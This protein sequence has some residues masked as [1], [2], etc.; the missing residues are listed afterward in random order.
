M[1]A[2]ARHAARPTFI[3]MFTKSR[4][5][6]RHKPEPVQEQKIVVGSGSFT[7]VQDSTQGYRCATAATKPSYPDREIRIGEAALQPLGK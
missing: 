4:S 3:A 2:H 6:R 1:A 5:E 7:S